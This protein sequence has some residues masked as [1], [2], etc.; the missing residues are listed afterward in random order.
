MFEKFLHQT[1][2]FRFVV[3]FILG[4]LI[5]I[6]FPV[7][8]FLIFIILSIFFTFTL[9]FSVLKLNINYLLNKVQGIF[10]FIFLILSGIQLVSIT[11]HNKFSFSKDEQTFIATIVEQPKETENSVKVILKLNSLKDSVNWFTNSSQIICYFQKDTNALKLNYGDQVLAKAYINEVT[12]NGNPYEFNYKKYLKYKEIYYQ[13]YIKSDSYKII[14]HEKGGK[15]FQYS[16]KAQQ[17]LLNI[18]KSRNISGDEFAVLSA[19]TLGYKNELTPEL[20][21]SFSASGAMH[22]L[23][24]SGLH[25]G[26]IFIILC[27]IL[28]FLQR[29]KY[30]K[31]I[32]S[33][34][35][36]IVL[37]FY[38]FLTGLSDSVFR[39]TIMFTFVCMGRMFDR[40]IN[41]YN[42]ISASAFL[43]L[44]INPYSIMNVGFQLSYAAVISIVFFQPKIYSLINF[45]HKIPDY[46]WQLITVA[47]A[48]QIGTFPI[49]IHYFNQFPLY[50][51]LSNIIIIPIAIIVIYG[52][53]LLFAFSFSEFLSAYISKGLYYVTLLLNNN[54]NFIEQ[55]PFSKIENILIDG[56]E[57]IILLFLV[58]FMSFFMITKRYHFLKA[59]VWILIGCIS[60][61][62]VMNYKISQNTV[63]VVHNIKGLTAINMINGNNSCFLCDS[64]VDIATDN[65]AYSVSPLW[66]KQKIKK[67]N[68]YEPNTSDKYFTSFTFGDKKILH[69]KNNN[70]LSFRS[71]TKIKIN[72]IILSENTDINISE[73]ISYFEFDNI[74]FDSSNSFYKIR[75]WKKE[76]DNFDIKFHNVAENGAFVRYL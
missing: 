46:I 34:I 67:I 24:V 39:A 2:F 32:Q 10:I 63:F 70:I 28:F 36:I 21:E 17:V 76:C 71:L 55:L 66:R 56:N 8:S 44:I 23:A 18:Y 22:I 35:I 31:I 42:T 73:L 58:L 50:F 25:V 16:H 12:S 29:N 13:T 72:Y 62:I 64:D 65:I 43:L 69:L 41:I 45:K 47:I 38:A 75:N 1:P 37:F 57:V 19:L 15:I 40:Q 27:K 30:G 51:I 33:V 54:V 14:A 48:A 26:I 61:N 49:T 7:N 5:Q 20:K 6:N 3:P 4:I 11:Q 74:I 9:L 59:S 68:P 60:Y 53:I 52:A